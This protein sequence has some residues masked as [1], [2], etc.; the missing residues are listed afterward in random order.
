MIQN[1]DKDL[2]IS[3]YAATFLPDGLPEKVYKFTTINDN[4]LKSLKD[5]YLWYSRPSS[6]ND[7]YDC[8]KHL[9]TFDP[10]EQDIIDFVTKNIWLT[11]AA[12]Q[13]EINYFLQHRELIPQAQMATIEDTLD[14]QGICCFTTNYRNTLMWSHYAKNHSGIC[15]VFEPKNDITSFFISKVHYT[16]E[17]TP[18]NYYDRNRIG[19]MFLIATKSSDWAYECEYR[20]MSMNPGAVPFQRQALTEIIFGCKTKQED[21][22]AVMNTIESAGYPRM[23]YT[24]ACMLTNSFLLDFK[25]LKQ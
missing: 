10:T 19:L 4:T 13:A 6:F 5:A 1:E 22:E 20:G 11:G 8:Y 17:F 12:L 9:L 18:W 23:K 25:S 24:Q 21:I 3:N 7:P 2:D 16:S 15:M 14:A